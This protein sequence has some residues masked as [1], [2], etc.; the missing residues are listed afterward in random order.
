MGEFQ[1]LRMRL[2]DEYRLLCP[3]VATSSAPCFASCKTE[4][5]ASDHSVQDMHCLQ[6]SQKTSVSYVSALVSVAAHSLH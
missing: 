5:I 3:S 4:K 6:S 2:Q 1:N